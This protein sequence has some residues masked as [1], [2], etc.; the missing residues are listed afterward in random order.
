MQE[1]QFK[2]EDKQIIYKIFAE[3]EKY[4]GIGINIIDLSKQVDDV[5]FLNFNPSLYVDSISTNFDPYQTTSLI[6]KKKWKLRE[7]SECYIIDEDIEKFELE[8][9]FEGKYL[10]NIIFNTL[11]GKKVV[12]FV[13][14]RKNNK[15]YKFI[16]L[17]F[18]DILACTEWD[19]DFE[20]LGF[21]DKSKQEAHEEYQR[22]LQE[23]KLECSFITQINQNNEEKLISYNGK[24][25]S[26]DASKKYE[27]F[28][29]NILNLLDYRYIL[30][31]SENKNLEETNN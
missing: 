9:Y 5:R 8:S 11:D 1:F 14:K 21:C 29:S 17:T 28:K 20:Y 27:L 26:K 10:G 16:D 2:K 7:P 22:R 15:Y 18:T 12:C 25:P 19:L 31:K 3:D 6:E 4:Q 13:S 23:M 30:E 24:R